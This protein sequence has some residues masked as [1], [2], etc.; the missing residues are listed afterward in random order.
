MSE[1]VQRRLLLKRAEFFAG[2]VNPRLQPWLAGSVR[3]LRTVGERREQFGAAEFRVVLN[4]REHKGMLCGAFASYE[5][6]A[7]QLMIAENDAASTLEINQVLPSKLGDE[8]SHFLDGV[9][10]F[11]V[12]GNLVVLC[13]SMAVRA[14]AFEHHLNWLMTKAAELPKPETKVFL[15]DHST[16]AKVGRIRSA[17]VKEV[18]IG[19]ALVERVPPA[20]QGVETFQLRAP[21]MNAVRS[22]F[23]DYGDKVQLQEALDGA[24]DVEL[25]V[26]YKRNA[27]YKAQRVLQNLALAARHL[28]DD[29]VEIKLANGDVVK[30]NEIKHSKTVTVES[31]GRAPNESALYEEMHSWLTDGL[32]S[33]AIVE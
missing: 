30:G 26:R 16:T 33:G 18:T 2:G 5:R 22:L 24:I 17:G 11:G 25:R 21:A 27:G 13:Q 12:A 19:A 7:A 23:G 29:D 20:A 6:G 3:S 1:S 31:V 15:S 8:R 28:D 14:K 4:Y 10:Y 32:R 9:C